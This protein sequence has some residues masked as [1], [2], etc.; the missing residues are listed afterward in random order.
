M[1]VN[2]SKRIQKDLW[3]LLAYLKHGTPLQD[4]VKRRLIEFLEKLPP[5]TFD[6]FRKFAQK[7]EVANLVE[8][9]REKGAPTPDVFQLVSRMVGVQGAESTVRDAYYAVRRIEDSLTPPVEIPP[10]ISRPYIFVATDP[11]FWITTDAVFSI[12]E[13]GQI[14]ELRKPTAS[15]LEMLAFITGFSTEER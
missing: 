15:E 3:F 4:K 6:Y 7:H 9:E 13:A 1:K 5:A 12:G 11:P 14:E 2:L 8:A 10:D